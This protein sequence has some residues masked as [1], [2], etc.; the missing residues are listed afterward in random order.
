MKSFH[1]QSR[2]RG[3]EISTVCNSTLGSNITFKTNI[4]FTHTSFEVVQASITEQHNTLHFFC[5]YRPRPNR[6]NNLT[7]SM[8]TEQLPDLLDYVDNLPGF[9]CLVGDMNI[10]FDNPLQSLIKQILTTLS[11]HSLVQV[12]NKPTH[13]CGHIIDWVIV[14]PDDDIHKKSTITDSLESEHYCTNSYFNVSVSKPSTR[15][16][17][18]L[19]T[20]TTLHLLLNFPVFQSFHLLKRQA[21]SVTLCTLY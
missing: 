19:L 12:I 20:L 4:D 15:L 2:S 3:G 13:R 17:G 10:D 5:L 14:R 18:T 9:V 6:R 7:D 8:F 11:L 1:R 21:S 16:L